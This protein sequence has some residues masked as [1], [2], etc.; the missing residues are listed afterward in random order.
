MGLGCGDRS[1]IGQLL[2][3]EPAV[4]AVHGEQVQLPERLR[5]SADAAAVRALRAVGEQPVGVEGADGHGEAGGAHRRAGD[6]L[7]VCGADVHADGGWE[8]ERD[9]GAV[10]ANE[11]GRLA[12]GDQRDPGVVG[13]DRQQR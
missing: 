5:G 7:G 10:H 6:G 1:H 3:A 8:R 9:D 4:L 11:R 2:G 13:D 12:G